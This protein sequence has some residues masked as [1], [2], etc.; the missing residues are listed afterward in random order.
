MF[1]VCIVGIALCAA[2]IVVQNSVDH[3]Y[4]VAECAAQALWNTLPRLKWHSLEEVSKASGCSNGL[5][6]EVIAILVADGELDARRREDPEGA[7]LNPSEVDL[8]YLQLF[9]SNF[10]YRLGEGPSRKRRNRR[11]QFL[12]PRVGKLA[13]VHAFK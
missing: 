10:E 4:E 11:T 6:G 9:A 2:A 12:R 3:L 8:G 5:L 13:G 1:I 7:L